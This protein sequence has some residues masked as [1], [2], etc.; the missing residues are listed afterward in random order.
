MRLPGLLLS[1]I[2]WLTTATS[3]NALLIERDEFLAIG[4][5]QI[6]DLSNGGQRWEIGNN[7]HCLPGG[8]S[9]SPTDPSNFSLG[10]G[11]SFVLNVTLTRALVISDG[12]VTELFRAFLLRLPDRTFDVSSVKFESALTLQS[13][14]GVNIDT[15]T[16][17]AA[18]PMEDYGTHGGA[19][20][21]FGL[22][23]VFGGDFLPSAETV[24]LSGWTFR[25]DV[26]EDPLSLLGS[27]TW[28]W[29]SFAIDAQSIRVGTA[30]SG[31]GP[32][33]VPEPSSLTLIVAGILILLL[34]KAG[35]GL[36]FTS[37]TPTWRLRV[38]CRSG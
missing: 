15:L 3:A 12:D 10:I 37:G 20:A 17:L 7:L 21:S 14:A 34:V 30:L 11:D 8:C 35:R 32:V 22:E 4:D 33:G 31:S 13:P 6:T 18:S 26:T 1:L 25:I 29:H 19:R 16:T 9:A 2:G 38:R 24:E 5:S 36:H 28:P 23:S 27:S